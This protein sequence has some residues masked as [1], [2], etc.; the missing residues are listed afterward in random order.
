M[1][2]ILFTL[3]P[4]VWIKINAGKIYL[5]FNLLRRTTLRQPRP[6][7]RLQATTIRKHYSTNITRI[8]TC[9]TTCSNRFWI[10]SIW[11]TSRGYFIKLNYSTNFRSSFRYRSWRYCK[12]RWI[13]KFTSTKVGCITGCEWTRYSLLTTEFGEG[14]IILILFET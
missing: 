13:K 2:G 14:I 8:L 1:F 7:T 5:Y 9:L 6:F 3:T 11:N 12:F 4:I 10:W